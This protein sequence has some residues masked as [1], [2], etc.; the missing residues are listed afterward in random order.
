MLI[1]IIV[2]EAFDVNLEAFNIGC[3]EFMIILFDFNFSL[4]GF[5]IEVDW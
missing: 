5:Y 4:E 2:E 3:D 1:I